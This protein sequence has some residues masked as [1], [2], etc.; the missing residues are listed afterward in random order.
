MSI[1]PTP[2]V[3]NTTSTS[4]QP[5]AY[6]F[7]SHPPPQKPRPTQP[8]PEPPVY[9]VEDP[10]TPTIKTGRRRSATV[11]A[12]SAWITSV[13][14]GAPAPA[15]PNADSVSFSRRASL[16]PHSRLPSVSSKRVSSSKFVHLDVP[17][18]PLPGSKDWSADLKALGYTA[19]SFNTYFDF[20]LPPPVPG[21]TSATKRKFKSSKKDSSPSDVENDPH[22]H[23]SKSLRHKRSKSQP[24]LPPSPKRKMPSTIY[25]T[26]HHSSSRRI[27]T[28]STTG[29]T[30]TSSTVKSHSKKSKYEKDRPPPLATE[31]ALAQFMSGGKLEDHIQKY[32]HARAKS[33]GA[34]KGPDGR[35]VGVSDV[36]RDGE[37]G[38]WRDPEERWEHA[39]L[40]SADQSWQGED[41]SWVRF[42][43][44]A[45]QQS[46]DSVDSD[47]DPRFAMHPSGSSHEDLAAFP[48]VHTQT[49]RDAKHLRKPEFLL[50]VF[51]IPA[52]Q[53][54]S[55]SPLTPRPHHEN[56][57]SSSEH[58]SHK[59]SRRRPPPLAIVPPN[60]AYANT[61]AT[62]PQVPRAVDPHEVRRDFLDS[63][64]T[65]V[66]PESPTTAKR[67]NTAK[68]PAMMKGLLKVVGKSFH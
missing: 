44:F 47:L 54:P 51:P 27:R 50:D 2:F 28:V 21:V 68:R 13:I 6:S 12:V 42:G 33:S 41:A 35:L 25:A 18:T 20:I 57:Y 45:S 53:D 1:T 19:G 23:S 4:I 5:P 22:H 55:R 39:H 15:S 24:P 14:P 3:S 48:T 60:P 10:S 8:L 52:D 31:L 11:S 66:R 38:V 16:T 30:S 7:L 37:G 43:S 58:A 32:N 46:K 59:S 34:V 67:P 64:F 17:V 26:E 36:Y 56:S 40:L 49:R 65:P 63:S 62:N 9:S 61:R 29:S